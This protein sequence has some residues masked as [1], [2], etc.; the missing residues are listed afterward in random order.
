MLSVPLMHLASHVSTTQ[1]ASQSWTTAV[2]TAAAVLTGAALLAGAYRAT[3]ILLQRTILSRRYLAGRLNQLACGTTTEYTDSLLGPPAFRRAIPGDLHYEE[4]IYRTNHAWVQ[5][6]IRTTDKSVESFAITVTDPRF[7]FRT[8]DLTNNNLDIRLGHT[9]FK[10]IGHEPDGYRI[11]WG[12]NRFI[13]AESHFFGNPGNYQTY[14]LARN[15][16]GTGQISVTST[17]PH[18]GKWETGRL[19]Q[20]ADARPSWDQPPCWVKKARARTAINTI[21]ICRHSGPNQ[22]IPLSLKFIGVDNGTVRVLFTPERRKLLR[23]S[24]RLTRKLQHSYTPQEP[25]DLETVPNTT[26]NAAPPSTSS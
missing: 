1:S 17:D 25:T 24:R 11:W 10:D 5:T 22:P 15:D 4:H 16:A 2:Q 21:L 23:G 6:I 20:A 13:H 3:K 12:A 18:A 8:R 7:A 19:Q 9:L 14:V 26:R